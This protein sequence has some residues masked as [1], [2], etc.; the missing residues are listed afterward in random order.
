MEKWSEIEK[1]SKKKHNQSWI[2]TMRAI[3]SSES[4]SYRSIHRPLLKWPV[5]ILCFTTGIV[6]IGMHI[7]AMA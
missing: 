3:A 1:Y 7:S 5:F 2:R 4:I 6:I